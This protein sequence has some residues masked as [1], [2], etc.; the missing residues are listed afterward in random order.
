MKIK[1]LVIVAVALCA[2]FGSCKSTRNIKSFST[3]D[4]LSYAAGVQFGTSFKSQDSTLNGAIMGA[5]LAD[6]FAGEALMT[7]EEATAFIQ[8]WFS[9]RKPA[10]DMAGSLEWLEKVKAENPNIQT[11]ESGLMYEI[12][13]AGDQAVKALN[14]ADQV[15]VNYRGSLRDGS[16][17]DAGEGVSFP[18]NRVIAGWT[19]GM[20]LVG[21]GGKINLWIPSELGYG[22]GGSGPIPPNSALKFEVELIDVIPAAAE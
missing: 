6:V 10:M 15:T 7:M 22:P 4:S 3:N 17:F 8:E 9:V 20:K 12:I 18:L 13:E 14:D 11:T 16:E 2:A 19:E 1:G 21:K 5:A